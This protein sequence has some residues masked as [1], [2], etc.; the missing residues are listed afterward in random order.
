MAQ[1][2]TNSI[3]EHK[4]QIIPIEFD[5]IESNVKNESIDFLITNTMNYVELEYKYGI[6]RIAT[7]KK[8]DK[9]KNNMSHFGSVIFT[10]KDTPINTIDDLYD[11]KFGAVHR[12][13]FGGWIMA[14]KELFESNFDEDDFKSIEFLETHDN[15]VYSVLNKQVDAGTVR[16]D[17]LESM[18]SSG[19]IN[20]NDFKIINQQNANFRSFPFLLS[21]ELYPEWPLA[22]L[23][24]SSQKHSNMLLIA[25]L[26]ASSL[27][28]HIINSPTIAGWTIPLDYTRVHTVLK[29]LKIS[30]Y[31]NIEISFMDIYYKYKFWIYAILLLFGV[32]IYGFI[33]IKI[34]NRKIEHLNETL[35]HKVADRTK[36]LTNANIKLK[37]IASKDFLTNINNRRAF[38][39]ILKQHFFQAKR[40]SN[41]LQLLS[42]DIDFFKSVNDKYGHDTGDTVLK[43]FTKTTTKLLRKS[44]I[45]GRV[46]G[47]EFMIALPNTDIYGAKVLAEKIRETI[48]KESIKIDKLNITISITVSIGIATIDTKKSS[49]DDALKEVDLALYKAKNLGRNR[50]EVYE[51]A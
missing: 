4:F 36:E 13:S 49:L 27:N 43:T 34:K 5:M 38:F 23:K 42:L 17:T 12:N 19:L 2:L 31:N 24:H 45:F 46:G 40:E 39:Q 10:L 28:K 6:S 30:P 35:E 48:S 8:Y 7:L 44:D 18:S 32:I 11:K 20:I 21:T 50:I 9:Y 41:S 15:V 29:E 22:K 14:K 16:S 3:E 26:E 47:E 25:L 33:Y 37:E 51:T 1:Y